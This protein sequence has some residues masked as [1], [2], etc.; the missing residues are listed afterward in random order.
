MLK[1]RVLTVLILLPLLLAAVWWLPTEWLYVLFAGVGVLIAWEWAALMGLSTQRQRLRYGVITA[2]LLS[3]AWYLNAY[4]QWLAALSA[5]WWLYAFVLVRGYPANFER[6]RPG[7][8]QMGV[9][10]QV[11]IVPTI[12]SLAQLHAQ[13]EGALRLLYVFFLIFAADTGAYFAGR[14]FGKRKLAP[15]VSPGKSIEGALGGLA[16]CAVWAAT[17]GAWVFHAQGGKLVALVLLSMAVAVVSIIGD[18]TESL[19]KRAAGVKDSGT[20]LPGHGGI[21]DRVDSLLAAAPVMALG[22]S[23]LKL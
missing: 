5:L 20:I 16:L 19:F 7:S 8:L 18:L 10:G 4:W 22:A 11:L 15:A 3:S 1:Q 13:P 21:L 6:R 12:L 17:A 2:I 14:R 9:I 23:L